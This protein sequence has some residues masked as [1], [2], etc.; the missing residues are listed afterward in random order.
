MALSSLIQLHLT[1]L[2]PTSVPSSPAENEELTQDILEEC[3]LPFAANTSSIVDNAKVSIMIETLFKLFALECDV[4]L[5]EELIDAVDKGIAAREAKIIDRR[6]KRGAKN[7]EE[8]EARLDLKA[9]G[10]RIKWL[11]QAIER[12]EKG[13]IQSQLSETVEAVS[14]R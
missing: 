11:L 3:F 1:R 7:K 5:T 6:K 12:K 4:E 2:F 14:T 9:S 10:Q 8:E 13:L